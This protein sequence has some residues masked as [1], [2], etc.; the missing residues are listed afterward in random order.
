MKALVLG[1]CH[2]TNAY[3]SFDYLGKQLSTIESIILER[4]DVGYIIFLGDVF[5]FR[6]PDPETIVRVQQFFRNI[7]SFPTKRVFI[8]RGNHDTASKSDDSLLTI[9]E[10]LDYDKITIVKDTLIEC[11]NNCVFGFVAHFEKDEEILVR[12]AGVEDKLAMHPDD[13]KFIFGHFGYT[14]CLN[15]NGDEDFGLSLNVFKHPTFLGHIHKPTDECNVHV[16]GTPYSTSF[17]ESDNYHRYALIDTNTGEVE[18][19]R[20]NFG[21]RYLS[22]EYAALEANKELIKDKNYC[23]ILRVYLSQITDVNSVDL[24]K[25]IMEEYGVEYVD[26]KYLPLIDNESHFSSFRPKNLVFELDD[27]LINNYVDECKSLL[28]KDVILQALKLFKQM[29]DSD[30]E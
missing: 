2:F 25:N 17:Q 6:K 20:I 19:K 29:E 30:T 8:V 22:F 11:V 4:E 13:S 5:H 21:I 23:T 12:L 24:R 27:E 15:T 1:D 3:P 26:I 18:F 9:L 16:V 28:P 7:T 10:V 14:G